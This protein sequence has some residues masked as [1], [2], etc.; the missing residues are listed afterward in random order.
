MSI[1]LAA[2]VFILL[3]PERLSKIHRNNIEKSVSIST[4]FICQARTRLSPFTTASSDVSRVILPEPASVFYNAPV[5]FNHYSKEP[6]NLRPP[7][8]WLCFP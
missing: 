2:F 5:N 6:K 7:T 3:L 1:S 8:L 4:S